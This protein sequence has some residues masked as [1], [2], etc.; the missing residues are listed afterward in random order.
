LI[1][2]VYVVEVSLCP[3]FDGEQTLRCIRISVILS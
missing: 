3:A 2:H 1:K